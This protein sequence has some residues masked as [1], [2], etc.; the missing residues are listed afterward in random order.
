MKPRRPPATIPGGSS[1]SAYYW[2]KAVAA[3]VLASRM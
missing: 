1:I 3:A 2:V